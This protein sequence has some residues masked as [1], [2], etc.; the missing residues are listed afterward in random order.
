MYYTVF[1]WHLPTPE[2]FYGYAIKAYLQYCSVVKS[3]SAN[4]SKN[5]IASQCGVVV[6]FHT[7]PDPDRCIEP[8]NFTDRKAVSFSFTFYFNTYARY[9]Y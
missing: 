7:L 9:F 5:Q 1:K 6:R 4:Y 8:R 3:K 2:D